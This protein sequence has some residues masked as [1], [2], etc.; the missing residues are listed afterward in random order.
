MATTIPCPMC[1]GPIPSDAYWCKNCGRNLPSGQ[2]PP[3]QLLT[4]AALT[5]DMTEQQRWLFQSQFDAARKHEGTGIVL[6]LL[7]GGLGAHR[8][9]LGE[10]G[11]GVL[12]VLFVWTF[13]PAIIAFFEL[14]VMS[15]RVRAYN[16]RKALEI[17]AQV[18]MLRNPRVTP[19][20]Q[21]TGN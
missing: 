16:A 10:I 14:F 3:Q 9:Y 8:F 6:A 12:Y 15:K 18:Q 7:L 20:T 1:G 21:P 11:L 17:A 5:Q 19:A 4:Q 13:V 2:P